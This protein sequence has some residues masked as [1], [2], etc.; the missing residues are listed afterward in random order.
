MKAFQRYLDVVVAIVSFVLLISLWPYRDAVVP[1]AYAATST[2]IGR[3][4]QINIVGFHNIETSDQ[5]VP[6]RWGRQYVSLPIDMPT[7]K[8]NA[9]VLTFYGTTL[10]SQPV[11]L[12]L[13]AQRTSTITVQGSAF[14]TYQLLV[15]HT[16]IHHAQTTLSFMTTDAQVIKGQ[17]LGIAVGN[18]TFTPLNTAFIKTLNHHYVYVRDQFGMLL[19]AAFVF[20]V[21]A[22]NTMRPMAVHHAMRIMSSI[23]IMGCMYF[24]A[25][26]PFSVFV[27]GI[28]LLI[29]IVIQ[30]QRIA[31]AP[32]LEAFSTR[33]PHLVVYGLFIAV[34]ITHLLVDTKATLCELNPY[35]KCVNHAWNFATGDEPSYIRV[36]KNLKYLGTSMIDFDPDATK[37]YYVHSIGVSLL[38]LPTIVDDDILWPRVSFI[39][40]NGLVAL[41]IYQLSARLTVAHRPPLTIPQ[42]IGITTGVMLALPLIPGANQFYPDLVAG[43]CFLAVWY[44]LNHAK[45]PSLWFHLPF[46]IAMIALPWLHTK[47]FYISLG[48][49]PVIAYILW[50]QAPRPVF[51][52]FLLTYI[53]SVALVM[54]YGIIAW[55]NAFGPIT[56]GSAPL[57]AD[58]ISRLFGLVFDQ[59]QG[60]LWQHP[61]QLA[62]LC[63]IGLF[64]RHN[65][66]L[67]WVWGWFFGVPLV[68][69]A[70]HFNPYG[71]ISYSGRFHWS[72]TVLLYAATVPM[73]T[74]MMLH[75]PLLTARILGVSLLLQ[76][77]FWYLYSTQTMLYPR[78]EAG[79]LIRDHYTILFGALEPYLPQFYS[80]AVAA[81]TPANYIWGI[82]IIVFGLY[83]NYRLRQARFD[84]H[85]SASAH[86][87]TVS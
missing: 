9:A 57:T 32:W 54:W 4:A 79:S 66:K 7:M 49:A 64:Y 18:V 6:F 40:L 59:N 13:D 51:G 33:R 86:H 45:R 62:G 67:F 26:S 35:I 48:V 46:I 12:S 2:D 25:D 83:A 72:S 17:E 10:T 11:T 41:I 61:L 80:L 68:L 24:T 30:P 50:Q 84:T 22:R 29:P 38:I 5:G 76:S 73:L 78:A 74:W 52:A 14:R 71:G 1:S 44:W 69:N 65:P 58:G 31:L 42:R 82:L 28:V 20:L 56:S 60:L 81:T 8:N 43:V 19:L 21:I 77:Y 15:N 63:G 85:S 39:L 55:G 70:L 87:T 47:N 37:K 36:A 27:G 23:T 75:W 34:A 16:G 3:I 53:S